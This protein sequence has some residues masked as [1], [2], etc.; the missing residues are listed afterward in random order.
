MVVGFEHVCY[1]NAASAERHGAV[2]SRHELHDA[3]LPPFSC[4]KALWEDMVQRHARFAVVV[5]SVRQV[6]DGYLK[7]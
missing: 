7:L 6:K 3:W 2:K 1:S 5:L 4:D